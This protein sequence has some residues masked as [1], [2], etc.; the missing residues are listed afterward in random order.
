MEKGYTRGSQTGV[1]LRPSWQSSVPT[2]LCDLQDH[3]AARD[4]FTS[5]S[6]GFFGGGGNAESPEA[7][8][9]SSP[10]FGMLKNDYCGS[11]PIYVPENF[12]REPSTLKF[13]KTRIFLSHPVGSTQE[14]ESV[15]V[16]CS[17]NQ[18]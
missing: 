11:Y 6:S 15:L 17:C 12:P 14:K 18:L 5:E 10:S 7:S 2:Q 3:A 8:T 4:L 1:L 9:V 16:W 13:S